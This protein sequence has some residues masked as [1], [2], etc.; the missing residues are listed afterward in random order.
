MAPQIAIAN[1]LDAGLSNA[2]DQIHKI[3]KNV[4]DV[5]EAKTRLLKVLG[6]KIGP[7]H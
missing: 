6:P 7:S 3:F 5:I 1:E 2:N 4:N